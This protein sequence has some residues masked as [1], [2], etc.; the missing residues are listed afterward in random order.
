M[1]RPSGVTASNFP[2]VVEMAMRMATQSHPYPAGSSVCRKD[3]YP[4]RPV[5]LLVERAEGSQRW[6][7]S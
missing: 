6:H 2:A 4:S 5:H 7:R 1:K 3:K